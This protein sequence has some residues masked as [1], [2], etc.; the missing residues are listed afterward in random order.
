MLCDYYFPTEEGRNA[1]RLRRK[2]I[3]VGAR[4]E[5]PNAQHP[6]CHSVGEQGNGPAS[7]EGEA[8][9]FPT[10]MP[11][12]ERSKATDSAATDF[13]INRRSSTAATISMPS[14][15]MAE[16]RVAAAPW[17]RERERCRS[18]DIH[19][20]GRPTWERQRVW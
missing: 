4:H 11:V 18:A 9:P 14:A 17:W 12:P 6:L 2:G 8:S 5:R 1:E 13:I 19:A 7:H 10:L 16:E 15:W 3:I 20:E